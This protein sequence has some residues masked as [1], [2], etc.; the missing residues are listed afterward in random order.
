MG[1]RGATCQEPGRGGGV[2]PQVDADGYQ[3]VVS[4]STRRRL[5]RDASVAAAVPPRRSRI[6]PEF[7]GKCLNCLSTGHR[8]A[9][10]KLLRRCVRFHGFRH[11]ARD[12][13]RPRSPPVRGLPRWMRLHVDS[14]VLP[15]VYAAGFSGGESHTFAAA[16]QP[17]RKQG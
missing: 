11:L 13:K 12:C 16:T 9:T 3:E 15:S 1:A 2:R 7:E 4:R 14:C 5:G 8:V 10:C 6:P 17:G